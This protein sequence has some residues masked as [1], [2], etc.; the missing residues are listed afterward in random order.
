MEYEC[1]PIQV[2]TVSSFPFY[3]PY[4]SHSLI[5]LYAQFQRSLSVS[6]MNETLRKMR[7]TRKKTFYAPQKETE[8]VQQ[9][10]VE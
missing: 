10:V 6:A 1:K 4:Y 2:P 7:I 5:G 3:T 8:R 9:R